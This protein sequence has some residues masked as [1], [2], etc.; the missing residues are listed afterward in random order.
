MPVRV[1][2]G[3]D[4]VRQELLGSG[5][6]VQNVVFRSFLVIEYKLHGDARLIRPPRVRWVACVTT[7]ITRVILFKSPHCHPQKLKW[8]QCLKLSA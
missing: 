7:Q 1:A 4:D 8:I 5:I 2:C 3:T 6:A